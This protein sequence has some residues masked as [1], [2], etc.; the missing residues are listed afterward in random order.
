MWPSFNATNTIVY[1]LKR[2]SLNNFTLLNLDKFK[3]KTLSAFKRHAISR[4]ILIEFIIW[5]FY[6]TP[7]ASR[8]ICAYR[9]STLIKFWDAYATGRN[10]LSTSWSIT[11]PSPQDIYVMLPRNERSWACSCG[12]GALI[13][14]LTFSRSGLTP[15]AEI[16]CP[17]NFNSLIGSWGWCQSKW[18]PFELE[19]LPSCHK[20]GYFS[21]LFWHA[22]LP[23][24]LS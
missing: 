10:W 18:E 24:C 21:W 13:I 20:G 9:F 6:R 22:Y 4:I 17:R 12:T 3:F 15:S 11:Q 19:H 7:W 5:F 16:V 1:F 23:V 2:F 14:A 8:S